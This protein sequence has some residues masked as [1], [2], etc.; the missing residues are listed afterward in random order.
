MISETTGLFAVV[1]LV[2]A[3]LLV[4]RTRSRGGCFRSQG[5]GKLCTKPVPEENGEKNND[6][7]ET[8]FI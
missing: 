2:V 5:D 3:L 8:V 4:A 7:V 6:Q 1:F